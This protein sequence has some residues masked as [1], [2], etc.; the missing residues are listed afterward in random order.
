MYRLRC[1]K[2]NFHFISSLTWLLYSFKSFALY[3]VVTTLLVEQGVATLLSWLNNVVER[4]ML[5]II[6]SSMYSINEATAIV[7]SCCNTGEN[8]ID[9]T[10]LFAIIIVAQPC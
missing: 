1:S 5:F 7:Y 8:N 4:T 3:T 10:S 9:R 6:V 2:L